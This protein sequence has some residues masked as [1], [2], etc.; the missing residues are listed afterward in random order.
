[1]P[2]PKYEFHITKN[3]NEFFCQYEGMQE[4][5]VQMDMEGEWV[6][7]FNLSNNISVSVFISPTDREVCW[8]SV[9]VGFIAD[10]VIPG[11][12]CSFIFHD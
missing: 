1:M 12:E 2:R 10:R 7:T 3:G 5:L 8:A 11:E 9:F 6:G 4:S